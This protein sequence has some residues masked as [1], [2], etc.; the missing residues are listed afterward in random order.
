[1]PLPA[2]E[3]T[4]LILLRFPPSISTSLLFTIEQHLLSNWLIILTKENSPDATILAITATQA[5][6]ELEAEET[7][8]VRPTLAD[9]TLG[10]IPVMEEFTV[11]NGMLTPK[12]SMKRHVIEENLAA[13]IAAMY[14]S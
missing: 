12:L 5:E 11:D 2:V 1:M 6:L 3:S 13:E 14:E 7:K 9:K 10:F 4:P 8:L